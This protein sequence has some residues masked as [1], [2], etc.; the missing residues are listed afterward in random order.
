MMVGR[1]SFPFGMAY[2]WEAMLVLGTVMQ[3]KFHGNSIIHSFF[4]NL[5]TLKRWSW[6][7]RTS[8]LPV[9]QRRSMLR[10]RNPKTPPKKNRWF[11]HRLRI[12]K[13]SNHWL[14]ISFSWALPST[15]YLDRCLDR[16][17]DTSSNSRRHL[18]ISWIHVFTDKTTGKKNTGK[19]NRNKPH[20]NVPSLTKNLNP[21]KVQGIDGQYQDLW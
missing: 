16:C 10:N 14:V 1:R 4:W 13:A 11:E 20:K 2:F 9:I 15:R 17:L 19:N 3:N 6:E 12:T 21:T 7:C 18:L 5:G 8:C